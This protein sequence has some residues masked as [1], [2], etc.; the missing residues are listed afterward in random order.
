LSAHIRAGGRARL[1]GGDV[2]VWSVAE[3]LRGRRWRESITRDGA[4]RRSL[5]LEVS[6]A[7]GPARLELTTAAGLLTLHPD[8]DGRTLHGNV[9]TPTGIRHLAFEWSFEHELL[10]LDSPAAAATTLR[11]F[12]DLLAVGETRPVP[13]VSI[14]DTLEP[15]VGAW[16]VTRTSVDGWRLRDQAGEEERT[17]RVDEDGIPVLDG[18]ERWP[19]EL[20]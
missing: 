15:A 1:T 19:L 20:D 3:G 5:L 13:V 10:V 17:A 18:A 9:V 6:P 4:L 7:G 12:A 2:L 16:D 11:R 14:D 8:G